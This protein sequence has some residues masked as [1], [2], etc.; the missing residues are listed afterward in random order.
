MKS[1]HI[2][3]KLADYL[4]G[5]LD[6]AQRKDV[7][8]HLRSCKSCTQELEETRELFSVFKEEEKAYPSEQLKVKFY[9]MLE[10]EKQK[11]SKVIAINHKKHWVSNLLKVAAGIALLIG[12]FTL[13]KFQ[14]QQQSNTAIAVLENK[15]TAIKETAM[16]SLMENQSASKRIQ[17]VNFIEEFTQPDEAIIS[18]LADRMLLDKNTNVRLSAVEALGKFTNSETVKN[19]FITALGTEKDPSIQI[20]IIH[21]LAAIQEKK[22][23][24]PMKELLQQDETQPF[25]KKEIRT[26][27]PTII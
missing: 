7:E 1:N 20:V 6:P 8:E 26:L 25:V 11:S 16:L 3:H 14:Q 23:I 21:T 24:A 9:Q 10:D 18:A 19:T 5:H 27:L 4:D 2:T 22:A 13:G 15:S 17:G 12:A